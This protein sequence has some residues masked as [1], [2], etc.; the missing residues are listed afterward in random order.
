MNGIQGATPGRQRRN[1]LYGRSR[2]QPAGN[3]SVRVRVNPRDPGRG[4]KERTNETGAIGTRS[5]SC[6]RILFTTGTLCP[7]FAISF[8]FLCG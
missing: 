3:V 7:P 6:C 4:V 2:G 5:L 8:A 1:P